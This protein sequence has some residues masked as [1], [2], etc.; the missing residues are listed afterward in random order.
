MSAG[1][2][3]VSPSARSA[4]SEVSGKGAAGATP[5]SFEIVLAVPVTDMRGALIASCSPLPWSMRLS[6]TLSTD[7]P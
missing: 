1:V 5:R 7:K 3:T 6:A 4:A 2:P